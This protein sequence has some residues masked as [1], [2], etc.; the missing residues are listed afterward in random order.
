MGFSLG[1]IKFFIIVLFVSL[2]SS[3][4]IVTTN[5]KDRRLELLLN[6]EVDNLAH[7]Y[8]VTTDRYSVI[9]KIIN[10]EVFNSNR[11]LELFYN[12]KNTKDED[13]RD[14][15]R[16]ML[17]F[18]LL[19][20][21]NNL[22]EI[23]VNIV[24]FAFEDNSSFLRV[25][26]RDIYGDDLSL[27]RYSIVHTN[28]T[29]E[30]IGGFEG[31]KGTHA[32]RNVF[33][34]FYNSLY[35]GVAEISFSPQSM[36]DAMLD[37]H[38]THTNFIVKKEIFSTVEYYDDFNSNYMQSL[39]HEDFL[40]LNTNAKRK[41]SF[42]TNILLNQNLKDEIAKNINI[43]N[44]FSLYAH[45]LNDSYIISFLPI[46]NI[47]NHKTM[48]Y[49][50]SYTKSKYLH[51][52]TNE[53]LMV[54]AMAF[55]GFMIL[56]TVAY[57]NI[58]Q[59][60]NLE[61]IV[62]ERTK[63]LEEKKTIAQNATKAKSQFLANMSHEIRTPMNGIIGISH[64][65]L[66]TNL[67]EKQKNYLLKIDDSAK[68]LLGIINDILD[69][70]KIE[71]GKMKIENIEFN[72][73]KT[74]SYVVESMK[75]IVEDKNIKINLKYEESLK[76]YFYGDSL[77][78]SQVLTNLLSNAIKFTDKNGN[79]YIIITKTD[80]SKIKFEIK[81]TGIGLSQTEQK[82]LFKLFSQA[83]SSTTR[84]YG[85]TGLG[86][87]ISKQLVELMG[88]TIW[89]ESKEKVG[90]SFIFEIKLQETESVK[91]K[92]E[93]KTI[94]FS[95]EFID[96]KRVLIV[97]DNITNQLVLSGLLEEFV[98][99]IDIAKNGKEAVEMFE[100][101][102]YELIFMDLQMPVMDGYEATKIIRD[103]DSDVPIIALSA[104]AMSEEVKKTKAAGMN[105]HLIKPIDLEKLYETLR[106][107]IN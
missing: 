61:N 53:Y 89:V 52:M 28:K 31:G 4:Y 80:D 59:R 85:G 92:K 77:R 68:S 39:E 45:H 66:K 71:A 23:G 82:K 74:V 67:D 76:D 107:Y 100:K 19:P 24:N 9:S 51:D 70:S 30:P 97:E 103:M 69:F 96:A 2:Y 58:K 62:K 91:E 49:L 57:F 25:H 3:V 37:L 54:N 72:L 8:K 32:F 46:K 93:R 43:D 34:L 27:V 55:F 94:E 33:P 11:I 99:D 95:K 12:A 36:Q 40:S 81:D 13:E 18:E 21:F 42:P 79:I 7:S 105:E 44:S 26:K 22:K 15:F 20:H 101:G 84:K 63:E 10:Q 73:K 65:L 29:K 78:I 41:R 56:L 47:E 60:I 90:S 5:D 50:V 38:S 102:K 87:A 1:S 75:Y 64:L 48:A 16:S 14:M 86:L 35:L 6:Q 88:G 106:K 98:E 104:N 17:Y 83:D